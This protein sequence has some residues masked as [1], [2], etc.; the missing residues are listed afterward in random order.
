[1]FEKTIDLKRVQG[2]CWW[3]RDN[4]T[5]ESGGCTICHKGLARHITFGGKSRTELQLEFLK[6][7]TEDTFT[8][9]V[10][11]FGYC[12]CSGNLSFV[13]EVFIEEL[14]QTALMV[15]FRKQ[16]LKAYNAGYRYFRFSYL[17]N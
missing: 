16:L 9:G 3:I 10:K 6:R 11:K 14:P 15:N 2:G 8:I 1:M 5:W 13:Q 7:S 17:E 12:G 4:S